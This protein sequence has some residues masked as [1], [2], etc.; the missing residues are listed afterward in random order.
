MMVDL[1][2]HQVQKFQRATHERIDRLEQSLTF[3]HG[4]N[5]EIQTGLGAILEQLDA[6]PENITNVSI[7][8]RP[9]TGLVG[10]V[11]GWLRRWM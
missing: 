8:A 4:R 3:E 9:K 7:D 1:H 5:R 6:V 11:R 2:L 10:K